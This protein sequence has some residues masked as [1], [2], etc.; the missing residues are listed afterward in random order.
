MRAHSGLCNRISTCKTGEEGKQD[1]QI[2]CL[3]FLNIMDFIE[4]TDDE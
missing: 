1:A 3:Q 4:D 2:N